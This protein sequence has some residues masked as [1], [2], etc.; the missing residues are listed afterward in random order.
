MFYL[1]TERLHAHMSHLRQPEAL[2]DSMTW[3]RGGAGVGARD[4][5]D[6][7]PGSVP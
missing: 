6:S 4:Q 1:N 7:W 2:T 5:R 3:G